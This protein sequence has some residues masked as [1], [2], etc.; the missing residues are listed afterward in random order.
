M[1][2]SPLGHKE[3]DMTKQVTLFVLQEIFP[4]Q[5]SNPISCIAGRFLYRLSHHGSPILERKCIIYL[6]EVKKLVLLDI[7]GNYN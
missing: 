5:E 2:Y 6:E 4:T 3:S 7:E 1:G